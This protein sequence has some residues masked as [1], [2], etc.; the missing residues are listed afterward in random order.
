MK[1][2]T[3][4][5]QN[6]YAKDNFGNHVYIS[7]VVSGQKGYWC[8]GCGFEMQAVHGTIENRKKYF[9]HVAK[10]VNIERNCTF[11]NEEYR[12]KLAIEILQFT[13]RIKVPNLYSFSQDGKKKILLEESKYIEADHVRAELTFYEDDEGNVRWGKNPEIEERNLLIRPDLTFFNA[14]D[15]PLLLLEIVVSHKIDDEKKVKLKRLGIDTIQIKIP[16]DS[17]ENIKK[18]LETSINTQ[19]VY[20]NEQER[21]NFIQISKRDRTQLLPADE[22][23]KRLFRESFECR[24]SQIGNL[25]RSIGKC[26]GS[27]QFRGLVDQ[28]EHELSRVKTNTESNRVR[29][30]ELRSG[31]RARVKTRYKNT[32]ESLEREESES[33]EIYRRSNGELQGSFDDA[34]KKQDENF[35]RLEE[36][37]Q[38][39]KRELEESR[40]EYFREE[41]RIDEFIESFDGIGNRKETIREASGRLQVEIEGISGNESDFR[42]GITKRRRDDQSKYSESYRAIR[43]R[44]DTLSDEFRRKEYEIDE[45]EKS[46]QSS[47]EESCRSI[48]TEI[49]SL[50]A[51]FERKESAII[52]Y[53]GEEERKFANG[54]QLEEGSIETEIKRFRER[55]DHFMEEQNTFRIEELPIGI[56][57]LSE[58]RRILSNW[59]KE[60]STYER[61]RVAIDCIRKGNYKKWN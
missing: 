56:K 5:E 4:I 24:K 23:E 37:Y 41:R 35:G 33:A 60:Y 25:I 11:S 45:F 10:D 6:E 30:E 26:L 12:H 19:W 57:R 36:R 1:S 2:S 13:K 61:Y 16:K 44:I 39:T 47:F 58:T 48:E 27:Q 55:V 17:E 53:L 52:K 31:I 40:I 59:E 18:S 7:D 50:T 42:A 8:I 22:L 34:K 29:L 15:E 28:F 49:D 14:K 20:N 38:S 54:L 46:E 3:S 32:L 21:T 51:E 9:R 43:A